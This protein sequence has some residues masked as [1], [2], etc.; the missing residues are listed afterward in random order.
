MERVAQRRGVGGKRAFHL[1]GRAVADIAV[2]CELERRARET[3]LEAGPV[4]LQGGD[5]IRKAECGVDRLVV[6]REATGGREA[7]RDRGPREREFH[8]REGLYDLVR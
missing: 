6:P 7:P 5:E 4:T 2:E 1:E 3:D 8:V